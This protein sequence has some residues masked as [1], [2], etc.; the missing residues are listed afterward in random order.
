[1]ERQAMQ[2]ALTSP[3]GSF[4]WNDNYGL[5]MPTEGLEFTPVLV[6]VNYKG[7]EPGVVSAIA[8]LLNK[9]APPIMLFTY[10]DKFSNVAA[11][12]SSWKESGFT[13]AI[14]AVVS[15]VNYRI[16][17][18]DGYATCF[19][20]IP[21]DL[22]HML[23]VAIDAGKLVGST[24]TS[25]IAEGFAASFNKPAVSFNIVLAT[26][27]RQLFDVLPYIPEYPDFDYSRYITS[28]PANEGEVCG[29]CGKRRGPLKFFAKIQAHLC[30]VCENK[31]RKR[32]PVDITHW[33][34]VAYLLQ[35]ERAVTRRANAVK[36]IH[37]AGTH[38]CLHCDALLPPPEH[39]QVTCSCGR[40]YFVTTRR[41]YEV[42]EGISSA[43]YVYAYTINNTGAKKLIGT[44]NLQSDSSPV[45][46]C[47]LCG[48]A[49]IRWQWV[50]DPNHGTVRRACA[51]C[52]ARAVLK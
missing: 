13:S 34:E 3:Y 5:F 10:G 15:L 44:Y 8:E 38:K 18:D 27:A 12:F 52:A 37:Q 14:N 39:G 1:M 46:V 29:C 33:M 7:V 19:D 48:S 40:Q 36:Q 51:K 42:R 31:I 28:V 35:Q 25:K 41:V 30:P 6:H 43:K 26:V 17:L 20:N 21:Q 49:V 2:Q 9:E 16:G 50:G 23:H 32:G 11:L 24:Y 45:A 22:E 4:E 47:E